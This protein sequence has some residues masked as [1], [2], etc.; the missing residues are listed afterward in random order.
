MKTSTFIA[1]VIS[2][3]FLSLFA[4]A[5][6]KSS[7]SPK[8]KG[9]PVL[10]NEVASVS[11]ALDQAKKGG[12]T[13]MIDYFA[14]WCGPCKQMKKEAFTDQSVADVLQDTLFV[15]VD[16]DD[17]GENAKYMEEHEPDALPTVVFLDSGG[18]EIGRV[19]GYGGVAGFKRDI[20][21]ILNNSS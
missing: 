18:K 9:G 21:R 7:S 19:V 6:L 8:A 15:S 3:A 12:K 20:E 14:T 4:S 17:P 16:V 13:V 5:V 10:L 11:K 2:I 1:A